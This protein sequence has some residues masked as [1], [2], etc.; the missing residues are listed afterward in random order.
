MDS[1]SI[2]KTADWNYSLQ[3]L[4]YILVKIT[5]GAGIWQSCYDTAWDG[6]DSILEGLDSSPS[7]A[8]DSNFLLMST[9]RGSRGWTK[10][11]CCCCLYAERCG[12]SS[13][14]LVTAGPSCGDVS[15]SISLLPFPPF[16]PP[17][18]PL[19]LHL[20]LSDFQINK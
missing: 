13:Q 4:K 15:L 12:M 2:L 7:S 20:C 3:V 18:L 6:P 14:H 1:Q 9:L 8:L 11:L 16:I 19:C 17:S 10:C 5:V